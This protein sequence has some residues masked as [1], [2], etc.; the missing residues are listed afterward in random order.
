MTRLELYVLQTERIP[1]PKK[2]VVLEN[3]PLVDRELS[4]DTY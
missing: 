2:D 4:R 3:I 1:P